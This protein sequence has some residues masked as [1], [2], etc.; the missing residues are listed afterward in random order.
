[1]KKRVRINRKSEKFIQICLHLNIF[2]DLQLVFTVCNNKKIYLHIGIVFFLPL[3]DLLTTF[4]NYG[5]DCQ[6][7]PKFNFQQGILFS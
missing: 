6:I 5:K 3:Q 2:T 1:M 4:L 7:W